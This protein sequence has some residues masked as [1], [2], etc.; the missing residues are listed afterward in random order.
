[1]STRRGGRSCDLSDLQ[2]RRSAPKYFWQ[3]EVIAMKSTIRKRSANPIQTGSPWP[4]PVFC[5]AGEPSIT[6]LGKCI[7]VY[8]KLMTTLYVR[9]VKDLLVW[10]NQ[11]AW[12][13]G[14]E[15]WKRELITNAR[16]VTLTVG[17][18]S[19]LARNNWEQLGLERTYLNKRITS[20]LIQKS[21][22]QTILA[23]IL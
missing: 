2:R 6:G 10:N 21:K 17:C 5:S 9:G 22:T 8:S 14:G 7:Q 3:Q 18:R 20:R 11:F 16:L 19:Q 23:I 1:M 12:W 13:V 15:Y 4:K